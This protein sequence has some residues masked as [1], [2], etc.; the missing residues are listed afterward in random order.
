MNVATS[1]SSVTNLTDDQ[2]DRVS[3]IINEI[4]GI[5]LH[6]AK[7]QLVSSRLVKRLNALNFDDFESYIAFV[8][9]NQGGDERTEFVNA[10]TTNLTSFF[11]EKHHFDDLSQQLG[12]LKSQPSSRVRV[13]SAGCST[14]EEPYS[15]SITAI[16]AGIEPRKNDFRVLAT[17][18]DT[19]VLETAKTGIYSRD[20]II[21]NDTSEVLRYFSPAGS[22]KYEIR[23]HIKNIITFN[24]LNLHT[25]W[26]INGKFNAIFCRNVMIYFS[27]ED[28][29]KLVERFVDALAPGG[30]LYLGHSEALLG[31]I[32]ALEPMG[33]TI[34]RKRS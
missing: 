2:F 27:T 3:K 15:I 1:T 14:G 29:V 28:K 6:K 30:T 25:K 10:I 26:P 23:D 11:R 34:F 18:L 13:W 19:R 32:P 16:R 20:K 33:Q 12:C 8:E 4:A 31:A 17:D 21:K 22:D 7:I 9:G 24:Q 5:V